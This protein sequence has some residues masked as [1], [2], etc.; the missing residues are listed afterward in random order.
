MDQ[1]GKPD[2]LKKPVSYYSNA[3]YANNSGS[4]YFVE[5]ADYI[6]LRTVSINYRLNPQ[7][8]SKFKLSNLGFESLSVGLVGRN[9]V[10]FSDYRGWDPEQ[11]LDLSSRS[12]AGGASYPSTRNYTIELGVTF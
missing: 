9:I 10:S 3:L 4:T 12:A 7:Q 11:A 1:T 2:E 5:D 8:L 6:K